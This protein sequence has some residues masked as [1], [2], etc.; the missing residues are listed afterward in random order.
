MSGSFFEYL[1][2]K[3]VQIGDEGQRDIVAIESF[4]QQERT[5]C[6]LEEQITKYRCEEI[7]NQKLIKTLQDKINQLAPS[8]SDTGSNF[9]MASEFKSNFEEIMT[10]S[11]PSAFG[12]IINRPY[13]F[14]KCFQD[15][16]LYIY[17]GIE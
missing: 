2:R 15:I 17:K 1:G 9:M 10:A 3:G 14:G 8:I 12:G 6:R 4:E 5:I 11:L 16:L 7:K 13:L